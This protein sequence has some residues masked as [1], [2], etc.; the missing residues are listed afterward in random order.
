MKCYV[1]YPYLHQQEA[2]NESRSL[3]VANFSVMNAVGLHY[4]E[5]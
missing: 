2:N 4:I 3:A 5:K 1:K